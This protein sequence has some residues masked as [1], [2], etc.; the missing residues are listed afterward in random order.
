VIRSWHRFWSDNRQ[1]AAAPRRLHK[2]PIFEENLSRVQD[3][4]VLSLNE[5]ARGCIRKL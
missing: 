5:F 1:K 3:I 4:Q 2:N